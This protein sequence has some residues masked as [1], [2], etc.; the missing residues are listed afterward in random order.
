MIRK[1]LFFSILLFGGI[2]LQAQKKDN[3]L[4][5]EQQIQD[6][7]KKLALFYKKAMADSIAE[8]YSP[9]C[10]YI[11]D[12][13]ERLDNKDDV[14]KKLSTEFKAGLKVLDFS[15]APDDHKIYGDV[16]LEVGILTMKYVDPKTKSTLTEKYNYSIL[17]KESSD[18]KFRIR[19]EMWGLISNPCK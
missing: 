19:S 15:L 1:I 14:K 13:S 5:I 8:M 6:N 10:Y 9:N 11:R 16:V 12:F 4:K 7:D 18:K 3:K 17:W 2:N